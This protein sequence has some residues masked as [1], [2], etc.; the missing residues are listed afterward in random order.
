MV[1]SA[2][3]T[4]PVVELDGAADVDAAGIDLVRDAAHPALEHGAQARQ[5]ARLADRGEE[6]F[7]LEL[8][9]IVPD[10]GNLEFFAR[11]EVR[12]DAR[13]AHPGDLGQQADGQPLEALVG[14]QSQRRLD[15]RGARLQPLLQGT[16][17]SAKGG[18]VVHGVCRDKPAFVGVPPV[19][20]ATRK[21]GR[22]KKSNGRSILQTSAP[23]ANP[24]P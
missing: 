14:R 2:S 1:A 16:G 20:S 3:R 7:F 4:R 21:V 24:T 15:D 23:H 22:A 12:E 13:L 5:A 18:G 9:V 10:D 17:R 19:S 8:D 6:D 11:S